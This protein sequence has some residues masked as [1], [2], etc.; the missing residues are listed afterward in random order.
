MTVVIHR[1]L[2]GH[3]M[4]ESLARIA[5]PY[6]AQFFDLLTRGER[7]SFINYSKLF[8]RLYIFL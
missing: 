3:R 4:L 6:M 8:E 2:D 1:I 7:H 5:M